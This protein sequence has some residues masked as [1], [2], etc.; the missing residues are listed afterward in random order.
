MPEQTRLNL[1]VDIKYKSNW[2]QGALK[3]MC[4]ST[5]GN[6]KL[7][8]TFSAKRRNKWVCALKLS[9][10]KAKIFGPS[11]DPNAKAGPTPYTLVP[12]EEVPHEQPERQDSMSE[13][14]IPEAWTFSDHNAVMGALSRTICS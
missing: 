12:W 6:Q 14:R 2:Q 8:I 5:R 10:Q 4:A 13:P 11:G 9:L 1:K 3:C 7:M